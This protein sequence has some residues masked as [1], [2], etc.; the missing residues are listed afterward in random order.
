MLNLLR[1]K[2]NITTDNIEMK[3]RNSTATT[4]PPTAAAPNDWELEMVVVVLVLRLVLVV[5]VVVAV[6][7]VEGLGSGV[8]VGL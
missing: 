1:S 2:T 7:V 3:T 4:I 5:V 8:G 6:V